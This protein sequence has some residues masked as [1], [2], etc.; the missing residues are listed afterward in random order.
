[1]GRQLKPQLVDE[2]RSQ[3]GLVTRPVYFDRNEMDFYV[4]ITG[5]ED[6]VRADSVHEVKTKA[7]ELLAQ[8]VAYKWEGVIIVELFSSYDDAHKP[9]T[10]SYSHHQFGSSI[11]FVFDRM[12]RSRHPTKPTSFIYRK[13]TVDFEAKKP[14]EYDRRQRA[15][16]EEHRHYHVSDLHA[17]V[18]PYDEETWAGLH[19][20]KQSVDAAHTKL[21]TL[22]NRKDFAD[23][24]RMV[25]QGPAI[26]ILPA[27]VGE[28]K[29][30]R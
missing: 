17:V 24:L 9:G 10:T 8:A 18:M 15:N 7:K 26:P 3:N 11:E 21:H 5:P 2:V 19:A 6:R 22:V 25:G 29:G 23:K 4:E 12:E 28:S 14:S 1:M 16:N 13:H 30:R 20:L 27:A